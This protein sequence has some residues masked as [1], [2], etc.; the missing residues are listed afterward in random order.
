MGAMGGLF[1]LAGGTNGTGIDATQAADIQQGVNS[2]QAN[3]AYGQT[4]NSLQQQQALLQALQG[5]G[6]LNNQASIYNQ[7]QGLANQLA[8]S[9]G[10][11]NLSNAIGQLQ[12]VA[13]GT[14]PN[15]AQAQL[16]QDTG[17]NVANQA[18]LMAGQRGA[19][20]NVG[21][22]ARQAAQQG[23]NTQQQAV[24]QAA[25][26]QAQQSLG[27]LGQIGGL[28]NNQIAAQQAQQGALAGQA[29]TMASNQIGQTNAITGA[30]Q[31]Q[32]GN[33]LNAL[34]ALN[35]ANVGMQSN[36]NNVKGQLTNTTMQGQQAVVGGFL[37]PLGV[38]SAAKG[39]VV[40]GYDEGGAVEDLAAPDTSTPAF[41]AAKTG[42][43]GVGKFLPMLAMMLADGGMPSPTGSAYSGQSAFGQ[44]LA[45]V[46]S[47][48]SQVSNTPGF[49]G[50]NP[51]ASA[52]QKG[53]GDL[54]KKLFSKSKLAGSSTSTTPNSPSL[55][56]D[57]S[58]PTAPN[59]PSV[60]D[61]PFGEAEGGVIKKDYRGGG[62]VNASNPKQKAVAQGDNYSND[63]IPA[64]LSEHEIVL[65]RSVTMSK[66]P[67]GSAARF[68]Q[69]TLAK[70]KGARR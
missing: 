19:G 46:Q 37:N 32:Y 63:K 23:A 40:T 27:A 31:A 26:L 25:T 55:G 50:A 2:G 29:N 3:N 42:S 39:G 52:L 35:N 20:S 17:A 13:N 43:G 33:V 41:E 6:G 18:A 45:G 51:G 57:T 60:P 54:S 34:G 65:P 5:Q 16:A 7:Q 44:F 15:P 53:A 68:V 30:N 70:R 56:V 8:G 14:G 47:G 22:L 64:I 69:A 48:Q 24:G 36:I 58:M 10:V 61:L 28:A 9:N 49:S 4:Q 38:S 59:M 21:L 12:G 66:D 62:K 1:G 11:G 67:V